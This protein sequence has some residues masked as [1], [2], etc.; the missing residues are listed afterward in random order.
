META[1]TAAGPDHLWTAPSTALPEI[2]PLVSLLSTEPGGNQ[3][4]SLK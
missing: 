4:D 3:Y 1:D 2:L